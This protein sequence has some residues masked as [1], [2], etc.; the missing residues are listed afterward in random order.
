MGQPER[1]VQDHTEAIR[2]APGLA[3][4][5]ANRAYAYTLLGRDAEAQKDVARALELGVDRA[6]LE[7]EIERLKSQR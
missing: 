4:A 7:T 1:G 5:Y 2:L 3:P 6:A